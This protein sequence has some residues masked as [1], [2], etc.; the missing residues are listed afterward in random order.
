MK[1]YIL[2]IFVTVAVLFISLFNTSAQVIYQVIDDKIVM[3][4]TFTVDDNTSAE[5]AFIRFYQDNSASMTG[6]VYCTANRQYTDMTLPGLNI[7]K[8]YTE[9]RGLVN[10]DIKRQGK[11]I[12]VTLTSDTVVLYFDS[13]SVAHKYNPAVN[14]PVAPIHDQNMTYITKDDTNATFKSLVN[15]MLRIKKQIRDTYQG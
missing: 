1:N 3:Q 11:N 13:I 9:S 2:S 15:E 12:T 8:D 5:K 6:T 4:E 10:V 14:Y 7:S